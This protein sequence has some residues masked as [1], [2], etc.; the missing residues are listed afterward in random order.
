L[1]RWW[2]VP[3]LIG[4]LAVTG[5]AY[6]GYGQSK[7]KK[8]LLTYLNNRN[9]MAYFQLTDHVENIESMLS[10]SLVSNSPKQRMV[11]LADI[12]Q[13]AY[14]AQANLAQIPI[15]GQSVTRTLSFLTQTGDFAWSMA[16]K[17]ARGGAA[18]TSD[19]FKKLNELHT[20]AGFLAVELQNIVRSAVDGQLTFGELKAASDKAL[21]NQ[22]FVPSGLTK[23]EKNMQ[24]FPTLIYDGPFSDHIYNRTPR[25]LTGAKINQNQAKDIAIRFAES[26]S[27][28][29]Y[30]VDRADNVKGIIPAFRIT[31]NPTNKE[32]PVVVVDVSEKGGHILSMLNTRRVNT[33]KISHQSAIRAAADFL[34]NQKFAGLIPTY[35]IE[36]HNTGIVIFEYWQDGVLIYPDLMKVKVALDN[37][38][39]VGFEG[40][41]FVMNHHDRKLEKPELSEKEALAKV[42]PQLKIESKRLAVIPLETL[43][44]VLAYEFRGDLNGDT[45]IVYINAIT[46]EEERILKVIDTKSGPVTL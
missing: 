29:N 39:I 19:E 15:A 18:P 12:W 32:V 23:I 35:M 26:G 43:Q 31:L 7:D 1:R 37:G 42:N 25:G 33:P 41:S 28:N 10:K 46:G 5:F 8:Q 30:N 45:F 22:A 44:E 9:Q 40:T 3:A 6:W 17:Y 2:I 4:A 36:Q 13:H 20:Q 14:S 34:D 38:E 21:K 11:L 24:N 16:K 27:K